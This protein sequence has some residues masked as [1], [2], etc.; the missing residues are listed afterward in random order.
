[1]QGDEMVTPTWM[2]PP[3]STANEHG[4]IG[5][6]ADLEPATLLDAYT[7]GIFPMPLELDGPI[8]WWSPDP[9]A[10]I[11]LDELVVSRSLRR[12]LK[13][14]ETTID[15]AFEQV[16]RECASPR[17]AN[18][19]ID[20]RLIRAY[21]ELHAIGMA[22]SIETWR[23]GA[24]VGGLYGVSVGG[25]FAGE[26]MF[27]LA[28]DASKVALVRLV[29]T[30]ARDGGARLLDVQFLTPHLGSLGAR[31]ISRDD[32]LDRLE[33]ALDEDLPGDFCGDDG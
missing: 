28:R 10:I 25:L 16:I 30:L 3:A 32:Y 14:Y 13:R 8:A 12:S 19:W 7:Q 2:F 5:L 4:I 9:R 18:G 29:E 31:E 17:R 20:E 33:Q 26:S 15:R 6:G 23:D 11:E 22:H 21:C 27:H 1:M 24:L